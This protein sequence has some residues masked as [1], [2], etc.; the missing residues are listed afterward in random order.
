AEAWPG[1]GLAKRFDAAMFSCQVGAAK[2][3]PRIYL[4]A[5]TALGARPEECCYIGDGADHELAAASNLGM[6]VLR[7]TQFHDNDPAWPGPTIG[8]IAELPGLLPASPAQ[9]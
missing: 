7:T 6:T 2:P 1:S 3:D 4:A 9:R 5:T 8:S